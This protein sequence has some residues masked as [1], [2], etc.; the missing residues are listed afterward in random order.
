MKIISIHKINLQRRLF[1]K[2]DL[3]ELSL[4][5]NTLVFF[6]SELDNLNIIEKQLI[7]NPS[8]SSTIQGLRRKNILTMATL[9]KYEQDLK[10][11]FEYG[12]N[13]YDQARA[14]IHEI[15]RDQYTQL[16]GEHNAFKNQIYKV[17]KKFQL[18]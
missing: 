17:L 3:S 12:K 13:E 16:I 1:I 18:K 2:K 8:I 4:W 15:K 14:K 6:N 5:I 7:R 11:E 9:C 10:T